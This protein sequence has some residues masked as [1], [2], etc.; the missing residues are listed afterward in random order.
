MLRRQLIAGVLEQKSQMQWMSGQRFEAI[1][2][3]EFLR[4][5]VLRMDEQ[6]ADSN[7]FGG[8]EG[9]ED[10]VAEKSGAKTLP[11]AVLGHSE[12]GEQDDRDGMPR[13][14][15]LEARS[16]FSVKNLSSRE[17][18]IAHDDVSVGGRDECPSGPRLVIRQCMPLEKLVQ[19][20]RTAVESRHL[21]VGTDRL[22]PV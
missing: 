18:V 3:I 8:R 6:R 5:I 4:R 7:F 16:R 14:A 15:L 10:R 20:R 11:L 9:A 19:R 17:A 13:S 12:P 21:M 1:V 2:L 22:R